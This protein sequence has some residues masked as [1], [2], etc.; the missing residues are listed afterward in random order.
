V[1][2]QLHKADEDVDQRVPVA[3]AGLDR[4]QRPTGTAPPN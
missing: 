3:P 4:G 1:V 2:E